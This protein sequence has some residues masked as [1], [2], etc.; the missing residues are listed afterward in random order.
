MTKVLDTSGKLESAV[1]ECFLW[2]LNGV[3]H[4]SLFDL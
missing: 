3:E 1:D 4:Q 2:F